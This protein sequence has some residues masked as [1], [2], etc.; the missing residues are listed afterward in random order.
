MPKLQRQEGKQDSPRRNLRNVWKIPTQGFP[1]SHF[2]VFPTK[3]VEPCI[4]AGTS[5][6]GV[7]SAVWCAVGAA[8][9]KPTTASHRGGVDVHPKGER[10]IYVG[11]REAMRGRSKQHMG[12]GKRR[13]RSN[14]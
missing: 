9:G 14:R 12:L 8:R 11:T 13:P 1:G 10:A 3:L 5:E 4:K 7:C 6:K 2:A